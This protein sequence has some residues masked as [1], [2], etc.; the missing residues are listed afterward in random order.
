MSNHSNEQAELEKRKRRN[1]AALWSTFAVVAVVIFLFLV[2]AVQAPSSSAASTTG[3][4]ASPAPSGLLQKITSIPASVFA[5]IG[6]GTA[7]TLPKPMTGA[8]ALTQ[9]GKPEIV[10]V[11]AEYCPY[12][13][14]E[15]WPMVIA[16][17]RFGTFSN[18]Q[19]SHSSTSDAY[20]NTQTL[21]FHGT[22]YSSP[23]IVFN[24]TETF[25]N[26]PS[27][28]SYTTLDTPTSAI[29]NLVTTYDAPPYVTS[30][31]SIPFIDFGGKYV[32][33]GSTYSP[34]VLQGQTYD[35]IGSALSNPSN[36]ISQGAVGAAN[37]ITAAICQMT[38]NKP[39]SVCSTPSMQS[40]ETKLGQ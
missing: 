15:R 23:Y 3:T 2:H 39:S 17:S 22:N 10:Y 12:C 29:Q 14:T 35:Q 9:N 18:L 1:G 21:S 7:A 8:P 25:T 30:T 27:G 19:V 13:A 37:T 40:L 36:A 38:G 32:I 31:G 24:G 11:G 33:S 16:L 34:S 4:G 5:S 20:P 6:Q 26:I 28:S